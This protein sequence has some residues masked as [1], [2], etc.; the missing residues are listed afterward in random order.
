MEVEAGTGPWNGDLDTPWWCLMAIPG[1][2]ST[3]PTCVCMATWSCIRKSASTMSPNDL[4]QPCASWQ[5]PARRVASSLEAGVSDGWRRLPSSSWRPTMAWRCAPTLATTVRCTMQCGH[6]LTTSR[7]QTRSPSTTAARWELTAGVSTRRHSPPGRSQDFN[8]GTPLS[9]EV[10][11]HIKDVYTHLADKSLLE[12]C[13]KG[14]TQNPNKSLHSKIWAKCP[15]TEFV[16]Q[17]WVL[18]ATCAAVAEFNSGVEV[19]MRHLC[20]NMGIASG[21]RLIASAEKADRKRLH[22]AE[23]QAEA[24]KKNYATSSQDYSCSRCQ[25]FSQQI[26]CWWILA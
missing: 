13:L 12:R 18:S 5:H 20:D 26:C 15:K 9:P 16:G 10:T 2:T 8:V 21:E 6:R 24:S 25:S 23:R 4:T 22:E 1:R 14:K 11:I 7:Q 19:T 17:Q 3:W